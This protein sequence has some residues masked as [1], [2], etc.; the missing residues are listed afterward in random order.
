ML[1]DEVP[2]ERIELRL[3]LAARAGLLPLK[4]P[5]FGKTTIRKSKAFT[6]TSFT[7]NRQSQSVAYRLFT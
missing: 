3:G 1:P 6:V 7:G 5:M 2:S 4:L